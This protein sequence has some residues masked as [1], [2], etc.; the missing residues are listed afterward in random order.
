LP[1]A[2]SRTADARLPGFTTRARIPGIRE[3]QRVFLDLC[4][5]GQ[6]RNQNAAVARVS[7]LPA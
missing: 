6:D 5:I 3:Q 1:D 4:R 2:S 7:A